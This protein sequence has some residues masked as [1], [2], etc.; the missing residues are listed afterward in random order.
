MTDVATPAVG[1]SA[2]AADP[3][4]L[5]SSP[6]EASAA[7]APD[8]FT[9]AKPPIPYPTDSD[10]ARAPER[11]VVFGALKFLAQSRQMFLVCEGESGL[12]I[13][14]QHAAAER[15]TFD[16]LRARSRSNT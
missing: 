6:P 16:R 12:M 1:L 8:L 4:G 9:E 7:A 5:A 2:P 3:W 10:R 14:D 11:P 13:L 15:V